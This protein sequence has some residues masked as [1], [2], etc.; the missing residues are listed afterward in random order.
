MIVEIPSVPGF[1]SIGVTAAI[2]RGEGTIPVEREECI[3]SVMRGAREGAMA[4]TREVGWGSTCQV[5]GLDFL[6]R[7]VVSETDGRAKAES[8]WEGVGEGSV[9]DELREEL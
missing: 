8:D 3:M 7:S 6:I 4:L 2:L 1:L 9:E 5:E